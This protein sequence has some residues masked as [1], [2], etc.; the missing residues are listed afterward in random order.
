MNS[1]GSAT[2][3]ITLDHGISRVNVKIEAEN[4]TE[5]N[6][7]GPFTSQCTKIQTISY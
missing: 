2:D 1:L 6:G 5:I 3:F 4:E 7:M